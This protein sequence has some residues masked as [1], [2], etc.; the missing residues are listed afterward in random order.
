MDTVGEFPSEDAWPELGQDGGRWKSKFAALDAPDEF[1]NSINN[2]TENWNKDRYAA[3]SFRWSGVRS[4]RSFP[5]QIDFL[6][7][8]S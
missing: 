2:G 4:D 5:S 6:R 1:A 7:M 8:N 3:W